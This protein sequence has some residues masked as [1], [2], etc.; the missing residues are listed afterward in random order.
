MNK[1]ELTGTPRT[2]TGTKYAAQLRRS[3]QVPCV[4]YGG[5]NTIHF[6][7]DE[8]ALGKVVFT[9]EMRGIE[10]DIA[11]TKTLAMVH[12]KQFHPTTDRVIHVDFVE[13]NENKETQAYLSVRLKGQP[14][15]VRKGGNL[16]HTMRKMRVKGLPMKFP[17][18]LEVNIADLDINKSIHVADLK[19][20]G[21]TLLERPDDVVVS[22]KVAKKVEEA[23]PAAGAAA[24]P[25]AG[26]AATPA[27]APAADAKKGAE[28]KPAAKP[29]AKK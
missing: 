6:S 2:S 29:A 10:L 28:A 27:A 1:I 17:T 7:V 16:N 26:A 12:Q 20:P 5:A 8:A 18:H 11:G 23:T 9:A 25:A 24:A 3:K 19:F 13:L 15:G 14:I 22:V 4:L 21:L